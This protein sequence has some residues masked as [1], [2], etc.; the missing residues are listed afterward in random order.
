MLVA[1]VVDIW[2]A[3]GQTP[4]QA[5]KSSLP[6]LAALVAVVSLTSSAINSAANH[7]RQLR[8][9]TLKAY[10]DW[11]DSTLDQRVSLRESLGEK[12]LSQSIAAELAGD[13]NASQELTDEVRTTVRKEIVEVLNGLERVAVG[14]ELG[15]Y[16]LVTLRSL[17]GTIIVRY[18]ERFEPYVSAKRGLSNPALRQ[19]AIYLALE[20]L[21]ADLQVLDDAE[22]EHP[23]DNERIAA[24]EAPTDASDPATTGRS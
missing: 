9:A 1:I 19:K 18:W 16:D 13:P 2:I 12:A 23:L 15:V 7:R 22:D 8:E 3:V 10:S 4:D 21:A 17:A 6:V 14:V 20:S 11:S 24:L 5:V